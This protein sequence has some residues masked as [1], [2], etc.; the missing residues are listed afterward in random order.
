M[1]FIEDATTYTS[2]QLSYYSPAK[3]PRFGDYLASSQM[4]QTDSQKSLTSFGNTS[5]AGKYFEPKG[6][7]S[8]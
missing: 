5:P 3:I 4:S 6:L 1:S 8:W 7:L 2:R